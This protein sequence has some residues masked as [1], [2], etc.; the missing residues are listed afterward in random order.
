[1]IAIRKIADA[2]K[3]THWFDGDTQTPFRFSCKVYAL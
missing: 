2:W 3:E 1:L